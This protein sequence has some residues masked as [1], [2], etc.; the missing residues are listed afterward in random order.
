MDLY[1]TIINMNKVLT[2]MG[3]DVEIVDRI[4]SDRNGSGSGNSVFIQIIFS[5]SLII[6]VRSFKSFVLKIKIII[7]TSGIFIFLLRP[8]LTLHRLRLFC[9]VL[10][11]HLSPIIARA[12]QMNGFKKGTQ[13]FLLVYACVLV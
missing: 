1:K 10:N 2:I 4:G 8:S 6:L 3:T 13:L 9:S 7:S 12:N 11:L 5:K